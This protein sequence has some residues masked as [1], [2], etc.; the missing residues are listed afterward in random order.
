MNRLLVG[1][2]FVS[3]VA[4]AQSINWTDITADYQLPSG[5]QLYRGEQSTPLQKLFYVDVDLNNPSVVVRPYIS[6]VPEGKE[7][8]APFLERVGAL[9]GI[10]GGYFGGT[11]SFSAVVYP[12]EVRAQNIAT[13]TRPAGVYTVTRAFWGLS[14]SRKPETTWIYHFGPAVEDIYRYDA[15]TPNTQTVPA[16]APSTAEGSPYDSLLAGIGGGPMLVKAGSLQYTYDEEVFFGSGIEGDVANPRTAVGVTASNHIIMLTA[17]GRQ[18]TST[19]V[20]LPDLAAIMISLGCVEAMNLDG[21]GSTQMAARTST[22]YAYVNIPSESRAVPTILAAVYSD[23]LQGAAVPLFEK[24]IDTGD[25]TLCGFTGSWFPS[26]NP[27]WWGTTPAQL[28]AVGNG[29]SYARFTPALPREAQYEV[30]AWWV[31]ASNRSTA[32][33]FILLRRSGVDTVRM[34]QTQNGSRWVNLGTFVFSGDSSEAVIVSNATSTG[35]YVCADALRFVSFDDVFTGVSTHVSTD[36]GSH[37][38]EQNYPNP[39][40]LGTTIG[41]SLPAGPLSGQSGGSATPPTW[42]RLAVYDILGREIMVLMDERKPPG[43]YRVTI[44]ATGLSSG[45]YVYRLRAASFVQART[46]LLLK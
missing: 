25:S 19:G 16:P 46:M 17:D 12:G 39:F 14:T 20:T 45:V 2:V 3:S 8:L 4:Q 28:T 36:P 29:E 34:D 23:S 6:S 18:A 43:T 15:P 40:N 30:Y 27:G 1:L 22:G 31:A 37:V 5:V 32:T 10:N 24:I 9:A 26:A 38:L 42:V 11:T 33:P 35:S 41:F 7:T 21:G 44:D 13:V